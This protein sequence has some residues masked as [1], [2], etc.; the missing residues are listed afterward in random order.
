MVRGRTKGAIDKSKRK[1]PVRS[2]PG[3]Y[4]KNRKKYTVSNR[5]PRG[6]Y[7]KIM[8]DEVQEEEEVKLPEIPEDVQEALDYI[9]EFDSIDHLSLS[10]FECDFDFEKEID[11]CYYSN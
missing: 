8:K 3:T 10:D 2:C 6:P 11:F 9:F 5:G 1:V 7:K 4:S